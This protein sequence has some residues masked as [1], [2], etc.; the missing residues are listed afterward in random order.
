M[1]TQ[2]EFSTLQT[3][4]GGSTVA[5]GKMKVTG[6]DYWNTPNTGADNSSGFSA[7]PNGYRTN[8]FGKIGI[9]LRLWTSTSSNSTTARVLRAEY[10]SAATNSNYG[11]KDTGYALR[12]IQD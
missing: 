10:N 12:L 1:P 2:A 7:L 3:Y 9:S 11:S 5:G 4:L 6:T 8:V